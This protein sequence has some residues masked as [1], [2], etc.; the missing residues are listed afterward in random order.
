MKISYHWLKN[1][2]DTDL[3]PEELAYIL[4]DI[5][6]EVEGM[7]PFDTLPGG[8]RG[9]VVG[10]VKSVAPHPNADR[11]R[12]TKVDVGTERLLDIVCGAPNVAEGQKVWVATVG[13]ELH[14]TGGEPFRIK[15]SK[16]RGQV[17]EGMICSELELGLGTD[18]E[19]IAVLPQDAATGM[20]AAV[21]LGAETD[22]VFEIGL[23]P[24]RTDAFS[25]FG[26]AR[27][28]AARLNLEGS[29]VA[30]RPDVS[31]F[32][33]SGRRAP[34]EVE[35]LNAEACPRYC[36]LYLADV[37]VGPSPDWL[38]H[39]LRSIGLTPKNNVVDVTNF[40]MHETGQPLHAFDADKIKGHRV[41]LRNLPENTPFVTLDGVERKLRS[42]DLLICD[43]E[44]P[45][46]LAGVLG[47]SESGV[48]DHTR[49]LFLESA[50]FDAATIR[51]T[52]KHHAIH[53][54]ASFRF[55]RGVDP[56]DTTY[57]LKRA[58]MLLKDLAGAEIAEPLYDIRGEI[59]D[60][61]RIPFRLSRFELLTGLKLE[62][63]RVENILASLD[64]GVIDKTEDGYVLEAPTY[65]VD[66]TREEDVVEE[67]LRIR[68]FNTVELPERMSISVQ[69]LPP[70]SPSE[71]VHTVSEHL[72]GKGFNEAMSNGLTSSKSILGAMGEKAED[73]LVF[74]QNP[75]SR[76][77]DVLRP[78]L[79]V[80]ALENLAYNLNRQTERLMYFE[81]GTVYRMDAGK[82]VETHALS[83][84]L[85][86]SRLPENWN[87]PPGDFD[88][89]DIRG[90]MQSVLDGL[91]LSNPVYAPVSHP[92]LQGAQEIT[93][94]GKRVGT[95]GRLS[96][97][98]RKVYDVKRDALYGELDF[99][100]CL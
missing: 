69:P 7:E 78:T 63:D 34:L 95:L 57:A 36:G 88:H 79:A 1:Y 94:H 71:V 43:A 61:V 17:S 28:L 60:P 53:T 44:G 37:Q 82:Y 87:N 74:M 29:A 19:G 3:S 93:V 54:D 56:L 33:T 50:C 100:A 10:E 65:R 8:L 42:D 22:T 84:T 80:S 90:Y 2:I 62:A 23:T 86:G 30:S 85:C 59:S 26:V 15:K 55:E 51:R 48:S 97:K 58:A 66:V 96:G 11:L 70:P 25:H 83:L 68:G 98:A 45:M 13:A 47:G 20:D 12:L 31:A 81:F 6:L 16:I 92:F 38:Q 39:R 75:L 67:V 46:C 99:T 49:N 21:Y 5:G 4:T 14:P 40:V 91:G 27:D 18:G 32:S 76:D 64:F 72:V 9:V 89:S 24:N 73:T 35:V 77:L 52:S 41:V